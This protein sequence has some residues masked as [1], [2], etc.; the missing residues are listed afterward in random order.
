MLYVSAKYQTAI[1]LC[2]CGC[3]MEVVTPLG[4]GGWS[5]ATDGEKVTLSPSIGNYQIPCRSHY[6]IRESR[7]VWA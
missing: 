2:T 1:H 3:Q 7:V 6:W 4:Q 5:A